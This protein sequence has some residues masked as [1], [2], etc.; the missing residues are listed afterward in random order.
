MPPREDVSAEAP[1]VLLVKDRLLVYLPVP[2]GLARRCQFKRQPIRRLAALARAHRTV[3]CE[4]VRDLA[5]ELAP[6]LAHGERS[7]VA[8][9]PHVLQFRRILVDRVGLVLPHV[10]DDSSDRMVWICRLHLLR[11]AVDELP[12]LLRV[13]LAEFHLVAERI[14]E[15]R[16]MVLDLRYRLEHLA[17][18]ALERR[19]VEIAEPVVVVPEPEAK[20]HGLPVFLRLV[21]LGLCP[22]RTPG[23]EGVA[24]NLLEERLG[25]TT[26]AALYEIGLTVQREAPRAFAALDLDD[27]SRPIKRSRGAY[28]KQKCHEWFVHASIIQY[29]AQ[30]D[31]HN[32]VIK[33]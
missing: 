33:I 3:L 10:R 22:A 28:G 7:A 15:K 1:L 21:E 6:A 13:R 31:S 20:H 19:L 27:R 23:A 16:G 30:I 9:E 11:K 29:P 32:C 25:S 12:H 17:L 14:A 24:A 26:A 18:R 5:A 4:D 8:V 2:V